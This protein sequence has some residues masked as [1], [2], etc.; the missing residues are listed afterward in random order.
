MCMFCAAI[1]VTAAVGTKLNADQLRKEASRRLP[2][3][4]WTALLVGLLV[5]ASAIY[6]SLRWQN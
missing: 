2:I 4:R 3:S 5:V 1:P 6:P